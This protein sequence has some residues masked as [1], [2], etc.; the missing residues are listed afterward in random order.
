[1]SIKK[2]KKLLVEGGGTVNWEFIRQ[3]LFDEIIITVT[4]FLVGGKE[5]ISLIQG[6][7]FSN[8]KKSSKLK[9]RKT[10]RQKNELVLY[11]SKL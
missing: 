3:G 4:P 8:I 2:K 11:Y 6:I 10:R 5:A 7:G 9:L 1:M